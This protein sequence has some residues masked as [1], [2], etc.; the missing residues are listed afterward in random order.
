MKNTVVEVCVDNVESL[1]TAI[2]AGA[3]RIELC[4]ALSVGGITP[5]WAFSHYAVKNS[6][7]PI[8]AMIRQRA[9]DFLFSSNEIDM[10]TDEIQMMRDLG[11]AGIVIGALNANATINVNACRQWINHAG[12]L[13]VTFHRA[14]DIV[15]DWQYSLEQV[16]DLGC[17][18]ILTSG[19]QATADKGINEIKQFVE[20][21]NQRLS[22]MP[23]CGVNQ[24]NALPLIETTGATEIHLSGK[25]QRQSAM[26][27]LN[28][29][30][31]MGA[32]TSGDQ[33]IDVTSFDKVH[34]VVNL[35][36]G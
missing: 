33:L 11:V 13:G 9:G 18:R 3:K 29:Q 35:L 2:D 34:A 30:V 1:H 28:S 23:G 14:F 4:S 21:A 16:I 17:E 22:I 12:D 36:N 26:I 20:Q 6:T 8:Y 7:V 31:S 5:S 27:N 24:H 10:M 32:E 25:T 19:Q 15:Q